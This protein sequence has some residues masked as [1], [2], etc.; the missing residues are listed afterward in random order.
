MNLWTT[1]KNLFSAPSSD[2][3]REIPIPAETVL[4]MEQF[5]SAEINRLT[6]C[7]P[8]LS[9]VADMVLSG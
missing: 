9:K 1:A 3:P 8:I 5:M 4:L 2:V 6:I 7:D